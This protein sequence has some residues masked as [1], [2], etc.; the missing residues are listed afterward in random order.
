[1]FKNYL[2]IAIRSFIKQKSYTI[3]SILSLAAGITCFILLTLYSQY[4][5]SYESSYVNSGRIYK[6]GQYLPTWKSNGSNYYDQT[7]SALAIGLKDEFKEIEY[8]ARTLETDS[9]LIYDY[10]SVLGKGLYADNDFINIFTFSFIAGDKNRALIDP[11]TIVLSESMA[12]ALFG[13]NNPIGKIITHENGRRYTVTGVV[14]DIPGNT[15]LRFSYLL[16]FPTM[17][18]IRNDIE[19][20][21]SILN[22]SNYILLKD[23][24]AYKE[25]EKKLSFLVNKYHRPAD[26]DRKYFLLPLKDIHFAT[27]VNSTSSQDIAK[28]NKNSIYILITIAFIVLIVACINYINLTTA[29][30]GSRSKE[31]GIRKTIGAD[32]SQLVKQFLGES[33]V[34][35][36]FSF[37][38]SLLIVF[39]IFPYFK[40]IVGNGI[41]LNIFT[42]YKT[43]ILFIG[44]FLFVGFISGCYPA[45]LLSSLKPSHVLK[46]PS[47]FTSRGSS[48]KFKNILLVFQLCVTIFLVFGTCVIQK[49]MYY[50]KSKDLGY[51]KDNIV[52]IRL[53][54]KEKIQIAQIIKNDLLKNPNISS[55]AISNVAPV[56]KTERNDIKA[57]NETGQQVTIPMVT[58]YYIDYDYIDLFK[59]K[60][61]L[62]KN[63][64]PDYTDDIDD[65]IILNETAAKMTGFKDPVGKMIIKGGHEMPI[66][67]VVKDFHY[68]SLKTKLEPLMFSY[69][70]QNA[71][72]FSV[73]ISGNDIDNT[74]AYINSTFKKYIPDFVYDYSFMDDAYSNLYKEETNMSGIVLSFSIIT[75]I[76]AS[77]G[78]FG[79][80][81]FVVGKKAK[82]IG[83]RKILGASIL[84]I[85]W[86][87]IKEYFMLITVSLL[88]SLPVAYYFA[89]DW[90]NSF[91]Y[92]TNMS[93]W[94]FVLAAFIIIVI[95]FSSIARQT[96]KAAAANPI[97]ALRCE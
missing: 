53:T 44:L 46:G 79:L 65:Q 40:D 97:N 83:V 9:P 48:M 18:S 86:L 69:A 80:I 20:N 54:N 39:I 62:G 31:V 21:W 38:I 70:P 7:S 67:G 8:T 23:N 24:V 37:I 49:Q 76:I 27:N 32:R 3:I 82:E 29:R 50:I 77:I 87:L 74:L 88:I 1:M 93:I 28:T 5:L 85:M 96:I 72:L 13:S 71:K 33:F 61:T 41:E 78:L 52:L 55:A 51:N 15:H 57:I 22:Y 19:S 64:S 59:M 4:E 16:S 89:S 66:I 12:S 47:S 2:N 45:F 94:L 14:K 60:I 30:A 92:H 58:T 36:F 90:L 43:I 34:F 81:S 73:K 25:F 26:Q 35:T 75:I 6:V 63:F 10:N 42:S 11:F 68:T 84:S 95:A 56:R 17:S 91:E